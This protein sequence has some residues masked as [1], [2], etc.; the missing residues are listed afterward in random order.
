MTGRQL[1]KLL[2]W[3]ALQEELAKPKRGRPKNPPKRGLQLVGRVQRK[4]IARLGVE[5][6]RR[7]KQLQTLQQEKKTYG[8]DYKIDEVLF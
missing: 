1:G 6:K 5:A 3:I 7:K 2:Q 8:L 4:R